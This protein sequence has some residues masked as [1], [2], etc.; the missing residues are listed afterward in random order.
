MD[1]NDTPAHQSHDYDGFG[2]ADETETWSAVKKDFQRPFDVLEP[3]KQ[4]LPFVLNSP[5]SGRVYP[6]RFLASSNLDPLTLRR[7]EDSFVDEIFAGAVELG[8]PLLRAHFPRAYLDVNREPYELDPT[9]FADPLPPHANTRSVRVA[10]GLGTIARV[11]SEATEIYHTPLPYSEAEARIRDIYMPFHETL[12]GLLE[13][14]HRQFG[15]AI[16]IDCHSMPSIGGPF[17]DEIDENRPDIVLG[18]RY[19]T[20]CAPELVEAAERILRSMGYRVTRNNPYAGGFNTEHYGAPARGLHA[21][22]IEINRT[23]YMDE[24]KV[25]RRS[26]ITRLSKDMTRLVRKLGRDMRR[27]PWTTAQRQAS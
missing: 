19:G 16:L 9:M 14:T 15:E 17:E 10:G 25:Q 6:A 22:Q 3:R 26:G 23:L 27:A 2:N 18:D 20:A 5:H 12:R 24:Q 1:L 8:A 13:K 4:T 7:S 11:V 21:I